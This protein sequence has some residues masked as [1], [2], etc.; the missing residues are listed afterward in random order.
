[1][2]YVNGG[3]FSAQNTVLEGTAGRNNVG[4]KLS[5]NINVTQG[6]LAVTG[7]I[8]YRNGDK[9]TGL[10]A[11][12]GLNVNVSHGSLNLTGQALAHPDVAGGCVS[13]P[14]GNNVVGLNLTNATLSAGNASLKGSSVY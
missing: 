10:L 11:G 5:G 14:S 13:T 1:A 7:T 2:L 6:N 9:F 4:A 8:Y 3:N 12:S